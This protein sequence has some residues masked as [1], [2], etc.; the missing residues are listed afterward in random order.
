MCCRFFKEC[1]HPNEKQRQELGRELELSTRQIKF[2]FQ[3]KRT[4]MKV[5][6]G[7]TLFRVLHTLVYP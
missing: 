2:W 3:N 6:I 7:L 1:P 4:K 5:L